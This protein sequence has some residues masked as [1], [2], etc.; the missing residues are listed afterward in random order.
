M[1]AAALATKREWDA[2]SPGFI[3]SASE[4]SACASSMEGRSIKAEFSMP[5]LY[6]FSTLLRTVNFYKNIDK[7]YLVDYIYLVLPLPPWSFEC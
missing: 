7:N 5:E 2:H 1:A 4:S 6:H 3:L